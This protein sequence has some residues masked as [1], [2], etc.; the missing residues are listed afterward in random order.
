MR[1]T[2]TMRKSAK[3]KKSTNDKTL[4][5]NASQ[6]FVA[7]ELCRRDIVAVVTLGNCPNTDL[8]C[9]N[10]KGT[11]F[12]HVQVKTFMPSSRTCSVGR[13]AEVTYGETFFWV[14]VCLPGPDEGEPTFFVIPSGIMAERVSRAHAEWLREPGK[15]GQAHNE[16][17]VRTVLNP[18]KISRQGAPAG[19]WIAEFEGR[20]DLIKNVVHSNS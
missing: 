19:A 11:N 4:R 1:T 20:W 14:L 12:A 5:G 17:S 10:R 18:L 9:S 16:S 8:L 6:F 2:K 15:R 3:V 7:G 13:K